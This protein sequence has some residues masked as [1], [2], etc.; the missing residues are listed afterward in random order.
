MN[1]NNF[2]E[3]VQIGC[4]L[5]IIR[6]NTKLE[7]YQLDN[8]ENDRVCSIC[9]QNYINGEFIRKINHCK[10]FYHQDCLDKWFENNTKCPEC[11]Y[12]IRGNESNSENSRNINQNQ[13]EMGN[14]FATSIPLYTFQ[15]TSSS[16]PSSQSSQ[17]VNQLLQ[18][19]INNINNTNNSNN[20]EQNT[21]E[22][23]NTFV[24][25]QYINPILS[26]QI[27]TQSQNED[28]DGDNTEGD[29]DNED[30][31]DEDEDE[32]KYN[33][34]ET[35]L[36]NLE[37]DIEKIKSKIFEQFDQ[38][39]TSEKNYYQF[40]ENNS[41]VDVNIP[42]IKYDL[43]GYNLSTYFEKEEMEDE[44]DDEDQDDDD[45]DNKKIPFWKMI[46]NLF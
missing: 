15:S 32:S 40:D 19:I 33:L 26:Q 7:L 6:I 25:I 18:N 27:R 17:F 14:I 45:E 39:E 34:Y 31:D 36:K 21:S 11:Q 2:F 12:D 13:T 28:E 22:S 4:S 43:Q 35:R 9:Q 29:D 37:K 3:P 38:Y 10:H 23:G 24:D 41:D 5:H 46:W 44:E 20:S 1:F 30:E 42:S 16:L 8:E